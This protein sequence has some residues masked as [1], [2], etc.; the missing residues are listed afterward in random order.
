[1]AKIVENIKQSRQTVWLIGTER[2]T[3]ESSL[4][5]KIDDVRKTINTEEKK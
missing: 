1:M 3:I 2:D 5:M 4:S